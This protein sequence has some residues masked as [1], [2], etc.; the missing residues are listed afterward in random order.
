MSKKT[1]PAPPPPRCVQENDRSEIYK[2][3]DC[4][5]GRVPVNLSTNQTQVGYLETTEKTTQ[6]DDVLEE[7]ELSL[8]DTIP[9]VPPTI[10]STLR[11]HVTEKNS[12][13]DV[14]IVKI[15]EEAPQLEHHPSAGEHKRFGE[16][17][18]ETPVLF[19]AAHGSKMSEKSSARSRVY[20]KVGRCPPRT[21]AI[22]RFA[23]SPPKV[24]NPAV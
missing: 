10:G 4:V 14:G 6:Q 1:K 2:S 15:R 12:S 24:E 19:E 23:P 7:V 21:P 22:K 8:D 17:Y 13:K 11:A 20:L 16:I 18:E 5:V 9:Q 3:E